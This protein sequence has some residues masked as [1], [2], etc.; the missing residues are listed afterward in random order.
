[1]KSILFLLAFLFPLMGQGSPTLE[2]DSL[3]YMVSDAPISED[4]LAS[5]P[6]K[7]LPQRLLL[8][9]ALVG[10]GALGVS[11]PWGQRA[12][13]EAHSWWASSKVG[14][15]NRAVD[16]AQFLPYAATLGLGEMGVSAR[17][18]RRDRI[19]LT[20][21]TF[22][23]VEGMT[24]GVKGRSWEVRPDGTDRHSFPSG[25]SARAFAG[26]ELVRMEYGA[27]WGT[28]AY[29]AASGVALWRVRDNRHW[30][31]DVIAGAGLGMLSARLAVW[32]LPFERRWLG[33]S[34]KSGV[35]VAFLPTYD[36]SSRA[37]GCG[38]VVLF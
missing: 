38:C 1:M 34:P 9:T 15:S 22:L 28:A 13:E 18:G 30:W 16:V 36:L 19:L 6:S 5:S 12:K 31:N 14:S 25:H 2:K 10:V 37:A 29:L 35:Q 8:P 32:L 24:R 26:A 3:L 23:L 4:A 20:A 33:F 17:H 7:F 27:E 21:T 11:P